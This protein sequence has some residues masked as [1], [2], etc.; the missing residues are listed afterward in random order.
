LSTTAI[1]VVVVSARDD[2]VVVVVAVSQ[3]P[4]RQLPRHPLRNAQ[5]QLEG[6]QIVIVHPDDP[7][8]GAQQGDVQLVGC[9]HL[10]ERFH[11]DDVSGVVYQPLRARR[12]GSSPR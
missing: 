4:P 7:R 9:V 1:V 10:H 12:T 11:P 5:I 6:V 2:D 8:F 3:P